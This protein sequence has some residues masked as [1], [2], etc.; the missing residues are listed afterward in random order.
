MDSAKAWW[1]VEG[2]HLQL[3][4]PWNLQGESG[5]GRQ[6]GGREDVLD[7]LE[8]QASDSLAILQALLGI[9]MHPALPRDRREVWAV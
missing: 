4:C 6:A 1:R 8:P 2:S 3:G 7:P 9:C 5:E